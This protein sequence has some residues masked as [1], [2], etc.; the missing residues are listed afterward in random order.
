VAST[1]AHAVGSAL[2]ASR[3]HKESIVVAVF[4]DGAT[5]EGAYHESLNFAAL[6]RLPVLFVCE[7]NGLAVHSRLRARQAYSIRGHA[8][9]YGLPV[10]HCAQGND[11]VRVHG[12]VSA[13]VEGVRR[14]RSPVFVEVETYRYRE[15]VGPGD[16]FEA[17]YRGREELL[18]WKAGDPLETDRELADGLRPEIAREIDDAVAFAEASPWPDPKELLSDVI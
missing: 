2:A 6:H 11:P 18:R 12:V 8:A 15:H 3:F 10:A 5:E 7:N 14:T 16:D 17:G 13:C 1:I 9:S 4:G